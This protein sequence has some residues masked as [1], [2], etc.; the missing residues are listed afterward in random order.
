MRRNPLAQAVREAERLPLK[1]P[2]KLR[3]PWVAQA[4]LA[5][6][7]PGS[8]KP[9]K[10]KRLLPGHWRRVSDPVPRLVRSGGHRFLLTPRALLP[11]ERGRGA[12]GTV[13]AEVRRKAR[14]G[15][16]SLL[17]STVMRVTADRRWVGRDQDGRW[18][19]GILEP[20]QLESMMRR[21]KRSGFFG[22]KTRYTVNQL[23]YYDRTTLQ[24][25]GPPRRT[26]QVV[27]L[28]RGVRLGVYPRGLAR[29]AAILLAVSPTSA[30]EYRPQAVRVRWVRTSLRSPITMGKMP[31]RAKRRAGTTI[32]VGAAAERI[33]DRYGGH[34]DAGVAQIGGRR[35]RLAIEPAF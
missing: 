6:G 17:Q 22:L 13:V 24:V 19:T 34:S 18:A 32:R 33:W 8:V 16:R 3:G 27:G 14:T 9:L 26:I 7:V 15:P 28:E 35:Y 30:G 20:A 10:G 29:S 21:V 23:R 11:H 25:F 5:D 31:F 2:S 4:T 1:G 12:P